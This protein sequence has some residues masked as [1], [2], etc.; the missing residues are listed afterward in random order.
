MKMLENNNQGIELK[1][2]QKMNEENIGYRYTLEHNVKKENI[3]CLIVNKQVFSFYFY[4]N[5]N[6]STIII[7]RNYF[8]TSLPF[9][10]A[11]CKDKKTMILNLNKMLFA[12]ISKDK[13]INK[14]LL[15]LLL[16]KNIIP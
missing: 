15:S 14:F 8:S 1:L 9:E 6:T 11:V 13:T 12:Y 3:N 2:I 5:I 4:V 7:Q 16:N 10:E